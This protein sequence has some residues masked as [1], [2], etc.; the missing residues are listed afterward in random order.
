MGAVASQSYCMGG[1]PPL[2]N[3]RSSALS[4]KTEEHITSDSKLASTNATGTATGPLLPSN[5]IDRTCSGSG[6]GL[7]LLVQLTIA[8]QVQLE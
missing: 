2:A 7:P 6:Y 8:R 1:F 3:G 4:L 5:L